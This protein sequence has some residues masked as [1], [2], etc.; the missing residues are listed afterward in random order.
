MR[1]NFAR[2]FGIPE[3]KLRVVFLDGSG[4]YGS[5]GNDDASADALLLSGQR[6]VPAKAGKLGFSFKY[7]RLD[8][9]LRSIFA[10]P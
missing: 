4:S 7:P 3:D 10:R 8:D 2:V 1:T 5:N 9:A 6:A